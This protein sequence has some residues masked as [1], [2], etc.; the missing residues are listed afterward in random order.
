MLLGDKAT[1]PLEIVRLDPGGQAAE[2]GVLE[3]DGRLLREL[4]DEVDRSALA[5]KLLHLA[6]VGE[7]G[8]EQV[9]GRL[10]HLGTLVRVNQAEQ[11]GHAT[12]QAQ[13]EVVPGVQ[14]RQVR[15]LF[16]ERDDRILR[17]RHL[18]SHARILVALVGRGGCGLG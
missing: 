16:Q 3:R 9:A 11:L 5:R 7:D 13:V 17:R 10:A 14:L 2:H 12:H 18:L 4:A 6:I 1:L 15:Q 8:S